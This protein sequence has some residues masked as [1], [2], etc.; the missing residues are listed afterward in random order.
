M[1]NPFAVKTLQFSSGERFPVLLEIKTGVPL[2][3]PTLY[4]ITHLR[5]ANRSSK[6]IELFLRDLIVFLIFVQIRKFDFIKRVLSN[7][8]FEMHEIE[9]IA[10]LCKLKMKDA[11][12][13][14]YLSSE[15]ESKVI[16]FSSFGKGKNKSK[17]EMINSA[18]SDSKI[19]SICSYLDWYLDYFLSFY[20]LSRREKN[21]L[22]IICREQINHLR[23][24]VSGRSSYNV[25]STR[26][27]LS[28]EVLSH[29]LNKSKRI[30]ENNPW[31]SS[32]VRVRNEIM[33]L[34]LVFLGLRR[35]ELLNVQIPDISFSGATVT[36]ARRADCPED[37][38]T[39]QPL[40]KTRDRILPLSSDLLKLTNEYILQH[41]RNIRGVKSHPYLF[42]A[43]KTGAPLSLSAL[44]RVFRDLD[45][46]VDGIDY[47]V[48][49]HVLRHTWNDGFSRASD[50]KGSSDSEEQASRAYAMGWSPTSGTA[51]T[52]TKRHVREKAKEV[53]LDYQKAI[54]KG[55]E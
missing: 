2:F 3:L 1:A 55:G 50:L 12:E 49:P 17:L 34:W 39:S 13:N 42:V 9:L 23:Q 40:V 18:S 32:F 22:R 33:I 24:R 28:E 51:A 15:G 52:Y 54:L 10:Y 19:R 41:R 21:T 29:L 38:R 26:E 25:L 8:L 46:E 11:L 31:S 37:P 30:S 16:Y 47:K 44:N 7:R 45:I 36:I 20:D 4:S 35:G 48:T 53:S 6:T 5:G 43:H 14:L 27:G